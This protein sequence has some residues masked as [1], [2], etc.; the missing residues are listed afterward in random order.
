M[1]ITQITLDNSNRRLHSDTIASGGTKSGGLDI[2]SSV[3]TSIKMPAA[4]TGTAVSFEKSHDGNDW[5]ALLDP[6]TGANY[7]VPVAAGKWTPLKPQYF[8]GTRYIKMVSNGTEE[9]ERTVHLETA[10]F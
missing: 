1:A 10:A 7:S 2:G 6:D 8:I 4:I 5:G 3:P 9:A